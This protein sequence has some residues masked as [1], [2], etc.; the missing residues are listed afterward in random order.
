MRVA[1]ALHSEAGNKASVLERGRCKPQPATRN[2]N[3]AGQK[4]AHTDFDCVA[5]KG[6]QSALRNS[7]P[8][9]CNI[10][11]SGLQGRAR[12]T[13]DWVAAETTQR[14]CLSERRVKA[15]E[16]LHSAGGRLPPP[17]P[18]GGG[19]QAPAD[20]QRGCLGAR[21]PGRHGIGEPTGG[22]GRARTVGGP[23]GNGN[24]SRTS[25]PSHLASPP[26]LDAGRGDP[27]RHLSETV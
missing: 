9:G 21:L 24:G 15:R 14:S 6:L 5:T 25:T 7:A 8:E 19:S 2:W 17:S 23:L 22:E 26:P 16:Y 1:S 3:R 11:T 4:P 27:D 13:R 10:H 18:V 12:V 20:A